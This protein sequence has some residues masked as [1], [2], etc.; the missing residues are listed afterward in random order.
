M[1]HAQPY[2]K[3]QLFNRQPHRYTVRP[4]RHDVRTAAYGIIV[5]QN[6]NLIAP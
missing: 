4:S 2:R 5:E 3:K 6:E 1:M